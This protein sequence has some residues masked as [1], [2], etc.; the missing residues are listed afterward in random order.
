[1][2]KDN[3]VFIIGAGASAEF[4]LPMG[5]GLSENIARD[6]LFRFDPFGRL[7]KGNSYILSKLDDK[8]KDIDERNKRLLSLRQIHGGIFLA[9]SIDNYMD[10]HSGDPIIA[11]MGKMHIALAISNAERESKL[12]FDHQSPKSGLNFQ[13]ISDTW[14]E[15]FVRILFEK[16]KCDDLQKVAGNIAIICFNYDRCIEFYLIESLVKT[17]NIQYDKAHEIVSEIEI[18]HPYGTLGKLPD[19]PNVIFGDFLRFGQ[20]I[21]DG[22]DPWPVSQRIKTFTEQVNDLVILDGIA[23]AITH[24]K[25]IVFLG[26]AFHPQNM[27]LLS[28]NDPGCRGK[29]VYTTGKG[30]SKQ[31]EIEVKYRIAKLYSNYPDLEE[32]TCLIHIEHEA[33][34][35]DLFKLHWRNLS[36]A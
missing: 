32:N 4:G 30:I 9:N 24:A 16:I 14:I 13:S 18:I 28:L 27:E 26:F 33:T 10:M 7:E 25:Q 34:C 29:N 19:S 23:N 2:F 22:F 12:F 31:E 21:K 1:M 35:A 8:Y 20:T 3:T 36:A 17:F 6:S 11:E 15:S 5:R